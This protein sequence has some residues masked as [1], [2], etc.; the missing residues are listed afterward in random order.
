MTDVEYDSVRGK[1][2]VASISMESNPAL[3]FVD[4]HS[5]YES[6]IAMS[7]IRCVD[8]TGLEFKGSDTITTRYWL[9]DSL[10]QIRMEQ[11]STAQDTLLRHD[12]VDSVEVF[13]EGASLFFLARSL[14]HSGLQIR[15]PV[16][17]DLEF[18]PVDIRFTS[19]VVPEQ[20]EALG[21]PVATKELYG[22]AHFVGKSLAGFSGD[23]RG[24]FSNDEAAIPVRAEMNLSIG[25]ADVILEHWSRRGWTPP[26]YRK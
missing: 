20:L 11:R 21:R 14:L 10:R 4:V 25:T 9:V 19:T 16:I 18:F 23:F 3:F 6:R 17:V 5:R 15:V 8:F 2:Y 13:Y 12:V 26:A 24:W 1:V 7:P 22:K